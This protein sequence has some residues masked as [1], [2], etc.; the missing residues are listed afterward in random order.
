[1]LANRARRI[2]PEKLA[3]GLVDEADDPLRIQNDDALTEGL[4][5]FF[6]KA[7][8]ANQAGDDLL[9]LSRFHA[10]KPRHEFFEKAGFHGM[11]DNCAAPCYQTPCKN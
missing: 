11:S 2:Q 10:V 9:H 1:L 5:D 6:Q 3:G 8:F 4:K 7:L